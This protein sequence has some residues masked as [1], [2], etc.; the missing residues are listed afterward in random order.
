MRLLPGL[1][2]GPRRGCLQRPQNPSGDTLS[3][4]LAKGPTELRAPGPRD[5]TIRHCID[6][7]VVTSA[8]TAVTILRLRQTF[9]THG[10]PCT[11]VSDNGSPFTSREFQQYCSMNGI[12]HIRSSPFHPASNGLAE[13]A[14]QTIKGG[15][16]KMG[17]DLETRMFEF[18]GRYRITPQTTTG[19]TPA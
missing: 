13:R 17:G 1:C 19:E 12:K 18:L 10:L 5:P 6:A 7:H 8:T 11:I 16:K 2:P 3:H 4:T 15:H 9:S 14:V